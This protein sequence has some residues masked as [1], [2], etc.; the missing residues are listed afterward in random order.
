MAKY[1]ITGNPHKELLWDPVARL[2]DWMDGRDI[3]Y[4][5][6]KNVAD[7]LVARGMLPERTQ[8]SAD[9]DPFDGCDFVLSFG[10][11]G[12]LLNTVQ[13]VGDAGIPILGVNIG[14]LGFLTGVEADRAQSAVEALERG[15]FDVEERSTLEADCGTA[16][17]PLL[18]LNEILV[19]RTDSAQMI[20]IEVDVDGV[21]LNHYW[22]DGLIVS[23]A[24]GSTAY[25]LSVGGPIIVP[26]S[27]VIVVTPVAPHMLTMRPIVLP[28]ST[29][30]T[31]TVK[32]ID[33]AITV[34]ADGNGRT[35]TD[36][37][38]SVIIR[39]GTRAV[40]LIKLAG[41]DY[42]DTLR[43]KLSWGSG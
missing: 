33:A 34:A 36:S 39:P 19:T 10:G 7:G 1:G 37:Q 6:H 16:V 27:G 13:D 5:L 2:I 38:T 4:Q 15:E 9:A 3:P 43:R 11:D 30:L 17:P 32:T 21:F 25:S 28:D 31:I 8:L 22:A 18:A 24:T 14:R 29:V 42:F 41:W 40:R 23:T 35:V 20:S 26:G 12:T